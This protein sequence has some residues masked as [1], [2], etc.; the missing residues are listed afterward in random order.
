MQPLKKEYNKKSNRAGMIYVLEGKKKCG[1]QAT[2]VQRIVDEGPRKINDAIGEV[3]CSYLVLF[4][5][6][7]YSTSY[8]IYASFDTVDAILKAA[9]DGED[10]DLTEYSGNSEQYLPKW[11]PV[12]EKDG[13]QSWHHIGASGIII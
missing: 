11:P 2:A 7:K 6:G 3:P 1:F 10:I 12:K 9:L 4:A 5:S 13:E 8:R